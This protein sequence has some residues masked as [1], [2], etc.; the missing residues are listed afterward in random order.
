MKGM[1]ALINEQ[2]QDFAVLAVQDRV[3]QDPTLREEMMEFGWQEWGVRTALVGERNY[4]TWGPDD[5]VRWLEG[6][7]LDQLPWRE[8]WFNN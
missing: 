8:F 3:I 2:G 7:T 5:I 6:V 4:R 1:V